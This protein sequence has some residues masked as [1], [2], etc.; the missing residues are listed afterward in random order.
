MGQITATRNLVATKVVRLAGQLSWHYK[1]SQE[2]H[3]S[4]NICEFPMQER[5]FWKLINRCS[6]T[7]WIYLI[8]IFFRHSSFYNCGCSLHWSN[9]AWELVNIKQSSLL[10]CHA[11]SCRVLSWLAHR[12]TFIYHI[13]PKLCPPLVPSCLVL[14]P[15]I[16]TEQGLSGDFSGF[17]C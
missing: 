5:Y 6:L 4:N 14:T 10:L 16:T 13:S 12:P 7:L 15:Q 8:E 11:M 1:E 9:G 3:W 17:F 2:S